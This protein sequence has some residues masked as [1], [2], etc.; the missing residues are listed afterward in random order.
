M[1]RF[2]IRGLTLKMANKKVFCPL[3]EVYAE[4]VGEEGTVDDVY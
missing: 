3:D 4:D 1:F 2:G